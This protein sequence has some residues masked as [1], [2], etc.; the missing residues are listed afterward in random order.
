M[1]HVN[2]FL[3]FS[4]CAEFVVLVDKQATLKPIVV[5]PNSG[6][7]YDPSI[8]QWVVSM[9]VSAPPSIYCYQQNDLSNLHCDSLWLSG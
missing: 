5:Y 6:E 9:Q 1:A 2:P 8:K 4:I 3:T 7:Q